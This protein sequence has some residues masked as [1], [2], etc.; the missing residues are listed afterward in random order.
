MYGLLTMTDEPTRR[1]LTD[2]HRRRLAAQWGGARRATPAA[3]RRR[4]ARS[5]PWGRRT[6][7]AGAC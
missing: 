7:A 2:E 6:P 3:P 1:R 4:P 5:R